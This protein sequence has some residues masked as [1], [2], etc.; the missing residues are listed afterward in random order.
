MKKFIFSKAAGWKPAALLK[1]NF[2]IVIFHEFRLQRSEHLFFRISF[3]DFFRIYVLAV[4]Q[5]H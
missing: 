4:L 2:F 3:S 1:I 5:E